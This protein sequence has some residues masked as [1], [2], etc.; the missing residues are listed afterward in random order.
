MIGYIISAFL[1]DGNLAWF[2]HGKLRSKRKGYQNRL[3]VKDDEIISRICEYLNIWNIPYAL[4][5]YKV[6]EKYNIINDA[7]YLNGI[8]NSD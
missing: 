7:L 3:A 5:P 1:G 6:S 8:E 2:K 4:K